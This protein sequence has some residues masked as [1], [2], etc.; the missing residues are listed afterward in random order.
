MVAGSLYSTASAIL[1][2]VPRKIFP[3]L[4]LG[5]LAT[6]VAVLL[7]TIDLL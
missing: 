1:L 6:I 4:V 3:D 7:A 2:M 5:S